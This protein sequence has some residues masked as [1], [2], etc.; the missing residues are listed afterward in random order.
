MVVGAGVGV[1]LALLTLVLGIWAVVERRKRIRRVGNVAYT[2]VNNNLHGSPAG[3]F[4]RAGEKV[5]LVRNN[6][7]APPPITTIFCDGLK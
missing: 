4:G 7:E 3:L 6:P 5:E 2:G 1:P